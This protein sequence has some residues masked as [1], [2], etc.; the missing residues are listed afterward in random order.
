MKMPGVQIPVCHRED[1]LGGRGVDGCWMLPC[2]RTS[3][4]PGN[5]LSLEPTAVLV[6]LAADD[7]TVFSVFCTAQMTTRELGHSQASANTQSQL[8]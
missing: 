7:G 4:L 3:V 5:R 8:T 2:N 6:R 1:H